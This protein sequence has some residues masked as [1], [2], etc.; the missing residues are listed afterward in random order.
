M[1]IAIKRAYEERSSKDGTRV[2]VDRVWPRGV[3]KDELHIDGWY[4]EVAPS[5]QLR[6]WFGHDPERWS[7]FQK[8]YLAEL[9]KPALREQLEELAKLGKRGKLT[10]VYG[11]RDEEHNQAVVLR[12]YLTKLTAPK[13]RSTSTRT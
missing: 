2:L 9:R 5:T 4:R 7:E 10:L 12:D 3:S 11:A 1:S 13:N 8:R 6:K